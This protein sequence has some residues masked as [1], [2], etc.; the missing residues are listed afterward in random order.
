MAWPA[1]ANYR[2][3]QGSRLNYGLWVDDTKA[4]FKGA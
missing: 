1:L 2:V 4:P 3:Y